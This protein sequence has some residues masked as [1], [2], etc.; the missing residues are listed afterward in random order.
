MLSQTRNIAIFGLGLGALLIAPTCSATAV[1][2]AVMDVTVTAGTSGGGVVAGQDVG[3]NQYETADVI[4]PMSQSFITSGTAGASTGIAYAGLRYN[5]IGPSLEGITSTYKDGAAT[6]GSVVQGTY[7]YYFTPTGPSAFNV[8]WSAVAAYVQ[9][10]VATNYTYVADQEADFIVQDATL[11]NEGVA[12]LG[13]SSQQGYY[14]GNYSGNPNPGINGLSLSV[15]ESGSGSFVVNP[16]DLYSV[17]LFIQSALGLGEG[18]GGLATEGL[19][20]YIDPIFSVAADNPNP[21][22]DGLVFSSGITQ[23]S[24]TPNLTPLLLTPGV[25]EPSSWAMMLVGFGVIGASY[26]RPTYRVGY[27]RLIG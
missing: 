5:A 14:A 1:P 23:A 9:S 22:V 13:L 27:P 8:S 3:F 15:V 12:S 21:S 16:G 17:Q 11:G 19:T 4:N 2:N 6:S 20:S 24:V 25:P 7:T 10:A 26:R 18:Q